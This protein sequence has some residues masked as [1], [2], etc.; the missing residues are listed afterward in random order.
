MKT[1]LKLGALAIGVILLGAGCSTGPLADCYAETPWGSCIDSNGIDEALLGTWTL[2]SVNIN[3]LT[4]PFNGRNTIFQVDTLG[5]ATYGSYWEDWAPEL[6]HNGAAGIP[7]EC[8]SI[9]VGAGSFR[10]EVDVDLDNYDPNNPPATPV[11]GT[12]KIYPSGSDVTMRCEA[13]GIEIEVSGNTP[14]LGTGPAK[15]DSHG[16]HM[17]YT[18][19]V[20]EDWSTLSMSFSPTGPGV[21]ISY[22][23]TR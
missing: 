16:A 3:G 15:F 22:T 21:P 2:Q 18:Y 6:K 9:G 4:H 10:T 1:Y 12:L 5:N 17:P 13:T 19:V 7:N 14:P 8:D 23:F 11:I 20:S